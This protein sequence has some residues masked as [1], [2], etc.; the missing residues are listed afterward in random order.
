MTDEERTAYHETGHAIASYRLGFN[1]SNI[2]II[3]D[4]KAGSA[5]HMVPIDGDDITI[6]GIKKSIII[7]FSGGEADRI[8][9]GG[10]EPNGIGQDYDEI[11]ELLKYLPSQSK[12]ALKK[13]A[14][15]LLLTNWPQVEAVALELAKVKKMV[16]DEYETIIDHIDEGTDWT[17][18]L[19][20]IRNLYLASTT[21]E[22]ANQ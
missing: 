2:S 18:D 6:D 1:T 3:P 16:N 12:E 13:E 8:A 17:E 7:L 14:A 10:L 4:Y 9:T 15:S 19:S 22:A 21:Q 5:G 11:D 20:A